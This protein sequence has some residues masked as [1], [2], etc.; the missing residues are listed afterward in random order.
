MTAALSDEY[1]E[2]AKR[3]TSS[4]RRSTASF[5]DSGSDFLNSGD[6]EKLGDSTL[7]PQRRLF[8]W[9][10]GKALP[11]VPEDDERQ[12]YPL[13]R[14]N[15]LSRAL[16]W[17]VVPVLRVGYRRTLQPNDLWVVDEQLG[18]DK[19]YTRFMGHFRRYVHRAEAQYLLTHPGA[20]P[21]EIRANAKLRGNDLLRALCFTF[22]WPFFLAL[23]NAAV[24]NLLSCVQPL[25]TKAIIRNLAI[26]KLDPHPSEGVG[27][28]VAYAICACVLMLINGFS[29]NHMTHQSMRTALQI[30][31]V[32]TKAVLGKALVLS[33]AARNEWPPGTMMSMV[34][35]DLSRMEF[36][37]FFQP[38][39][40]VF[41]LVLAVGV[42]L[43]LT[44]VGPVGLLGLA[45]FIVAMGLATLAFRKMVKLR[46]AA[47]VFTDARVT[48]M[49]EIMNSMKMLKYYC[50]ERAYEERVTDL[51]YKEVDKVRQ[52]M[53]F[54]SILVT[55]AVTLSTIAGMVC[56]L[57][58]SRLNSE[59]RN[60]ANVFAALS[61]FQ[62][63]S[64]QLFFIPTAL[65]TGADAKIA[66]KR[67]QGLLWASEQ[68]HRKENP[69]PTLE[70]LEPSMAIKVDKASFE[71]EFQKDTDLK[72]TS[73]QENETVNS[74]AVT[75]LSKKKEEKQ[76][77]EEVSKEPFT[78]LH[79]LS[80]SIKKGEFIIV[81]GAIGTGK[82]SL[83]NA[84][85]GYMK[86]TSGTVQVNGSLLFCGVPWIQ[87][88]T[89][90]DNIIFGSSFDKARYDDVV[91]VCALE[92]DFK[93]FAAGDKTEVGERGIT[94]SGGQK[95]R[96][97]LARAIYKDREIYL[98]DDII[99]AVDA[100]VAAHITQQCLLDKLQNRTRILATHQLSLVPEAS[101]I[102]FL[103]QD[104]SFDMGTQDELQERN[105]QFR[106]LMTLSSKTT[107][108]ESDTESVKS[109]PKLRRSSTVA[110]SVPDFD[111]ELDEGR[112]ISKEDRAVNALKLKVYKDYLL[113]GS[114]G[115][116]VLTLTVLLLLVL[117]TTFVS[118]FN[119][120]W[121]SWW[122]EYK[123]RDKQDAFYM[124]IYFMLTCLTFIFTNLEFAFLLH[125]GLA[126]SRK[127]NLNAAKRV[128]YAPMS[129]IDT[130]PIGRI[131]NRFTKDTDVLDNELTDTTRLFVFQLATV[132]GVFILSIAYLPY[133]A[134][135][136]PLSIF[137]LVFIGD[138]YQSAGREIK[139]LEAIQRSFV[140]N[141]LG[142]VLDGLDTIRAYHAQSRFLRKSDYFLDRTN[143]AGYLVI[144]ARCW[145]ALTTD[146]VA[147]AI[148]LIVTLLCVTRVIEVSPASAG[149]LLTVILQLPAYFNMVLRGATELENNM[150]STQ[151]VHYYAT[152]LPQ[153]APHYIPGAAPP[154][155]WP[156][157]GEIVFED[158]SFAYRPGLPLAL[159]GISFHVRA[160]EK[161]GICGRTGAGKTSITTALYRLSEL[162]SGSI[163][164]DGVDIAT[165]GLHDLR[166]ALSIIPQDPLLF[167][168][169]V[170]K[171]LDPFAEHSDETLWSALV[172][173]GVVPAGEVPSTHKFHL[174]QQ[175]DEGGANFSL[176][177]RQLLALARALVR[178]TRI[179]ILDEAT[180][181]V[182]YATDARVQARI[183]AEF[184]QATVLCVAHRLRTIISYDRILVLDQGHV[185]EFDTPYRLFAREDSLFRA[186]CVHAGISASDFAP[187]ADSPSPVATSG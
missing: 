158:V 93:I 154:T 163:K 52:M 37:V 137:L 44:T 106:A 80:F 151:R 181:S 63:L 124:G 144:G 167:R 54:R 5:S 147:I 1:N 36:A 50:W 58:M 148:A 159:R 69:S 116:N 24:T 3:R 172:R 100:N 175:V 83:L 129:F 123:F 131:L 118:L 73:T 176:G 173:S 40:I 136:V 177:E 128:L 101:R 174:D 82:T 161:I 117:L 134:I 166:S 170:R 19:M 84:M 156:A 132:V 102:I 57:A 62:A 66:L 160:G 86:K 23:V 105:A 11:P 14:A 94:L 9:V 183:A 42:A 182:D 109:S 127:L 138:H 121:L 2:D 92:A 108:E 111:D 122:T 22:W 75:V 143:E 29:F 157:A 10:H 49:R 98:F 20:T 178:S 114:R 38:F 146:F 87:N 55:T 171:N 97:S 96:I 12:P 45:V 139:R 30:R 187:A 35:T 78:G 169:T 145:V 152:A 32:L 70:P 85:A 31:T 135:A 107:V 13:Y 28:G 81:I 26:R 34:S 8:S 184:R 47:T 165:L 140:Y 68:G 59:N 125:I 74:D 89:I 76:S 91:R 7:Q 79:D 150:N 162:E 133:V 21:E 71:W 155:G 99:S 64:L 39:L 149:V 48:L 53:I 104:G 120:V 18:V 27:E 115:S 33:G 72:T 113:A 51:R 61:L 126:A 164:I 6:R 110:A 77:K 168:G 56:F 112:I 4:I 130:T 90:R 141:N 185:A 43:L 186:M 15:P 88:A 46:V 65:S 95:A 17:W 60:A 41:P 16:F 103:G 180:S 119:S 142:E 67:I 25:V 153:E 179:L